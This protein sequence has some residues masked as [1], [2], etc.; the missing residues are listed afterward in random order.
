[1]HNPEHTLPF[2]ASPSSL[3][4]APSRRAAGRHWLLWLCLLACAVL[5]AVS[6]QQARHS[7]ELAALPRVDSVA[8]D[9]AQPARQAMRLID[10]SRGLEALHLLQHTE[11]RKHA[12]ALQLRQY[13]HE[14]DAL[15]ARS[16]EQAQTRD[17]PAAALIVALRADTAEYA[18]LQ[19]QMLGLSR[20]ALTEP[21]AAGRAQQVLT[22]PSQAV[23]ERLHAGLDRWW[24]LSE[25]HARQQ[26]QSNQQQQAQATIGWQA[27]A[28]AGAMAAVAAWVLQTLGGRQPTR[29]VRERSEAMAS[30]ESQALSAQALPTW[31]ESGVDAPVSP[32]RMQAV[33]AAVTSWRHD[34][35]AA[36]PRP[37]LTR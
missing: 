7:A 23:F 13:R 31:S 37:T 18:A 24:T 12:L 3:G 5:T 15:L 16:A 6:L 1:M 27:L 9:L 32:S 36:L 25:S 35:T 29:Q 8:V 2:L 34:K 21:A 11:V 26:R 30:P 28:I 10:Q 20:Q 4:L 33:S 22:G 17:A 14:L 19:D